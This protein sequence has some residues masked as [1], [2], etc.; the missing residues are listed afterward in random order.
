MGKQGL[1]LEATAAACSTSN[2]CSIAYCSLT[3]LKPVLPK[4]SQCCS[5]LQSFE[6]IQQ[7]FSIHLIISSKS[8]NFIGS[9]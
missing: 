3:S 6:N 4:T 5:V 2:A 9:R 7:I 1:Q 8:V